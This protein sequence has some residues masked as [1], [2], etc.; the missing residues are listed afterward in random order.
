M[1]VTKESNPVVKNYITPGGLQRLKDELR[2]LLGQRTA[3][4]D[5][6]SGLGSEQ[7]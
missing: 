7:R 3:N 6:G 1:A 2:F 4:G 5:A